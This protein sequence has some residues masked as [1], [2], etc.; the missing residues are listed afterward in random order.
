MSNIFRPKNYAM[1]VDP[2]LKYAWIN[3]PKNASSFMQK[4]LDDNNW[5]NVPE[6]LID[7]II[8][9]PNVKKLAILRDPIERWISGFTQFA[10][11]QHL[12]IEGLLDSSSTKRIILANPVFDDHTE[13]QHRLIGN[14]KN[15]EYIQMNKENPNY[16]FKCL[17][18]WIKNTG[19]ISN[20]DTWSD[21]INPASI[22]PR[23]LKINQYLLTY[24]KLPSVGDILKGLLKE[25]YELFEKYD[26]FT[27]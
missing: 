21:L 14:A 5:S 17:G 10:F 6:D 24:A 22:H 2:K 4:V 11:D 15:L 12:D 19:G 27:N 13:F 25:D 3:I 7:S 26:K 18:V 20:F 8:E 9:S 23:K 16:F 1:K